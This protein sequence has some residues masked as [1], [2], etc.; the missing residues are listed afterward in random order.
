MLSSSLQNNNIFKL[1]AINKF[2]IANTKDGDDFIKLSLI[3]SLTKK[4]RVIKK[5]RPEAAISINKGLKYSPISKPP[6]PKS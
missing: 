2:K 5:K 4:P 3:L 1:I 6:A